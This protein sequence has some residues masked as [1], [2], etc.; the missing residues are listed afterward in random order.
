MSCGTVWKTMKILPDNQKVPWQS[1]IAAAVWNKKGIHRLGHIY[2]WLILITGMHLNVTLPCC[3][4]LFQ[5]QPLFS[6]G[7]HHVLSHPVYLLSFF[8][9][10]P[11]SYNGKRSVRQ[12]FQN[13]STRV[14]K[15]NGF[16]FFFPILKWHL[17]HYNA[18]VDSFVFLCHSCASLLKVMTLNSF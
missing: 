14:I 10:V 13:K 8:W 17:S 7:V 15:K 5:T 1:G 18:C 3:C 4:N 6:P 9:K 2:G 12:T 11:F 16:A